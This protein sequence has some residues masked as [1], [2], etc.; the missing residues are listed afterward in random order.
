MPQ[1]APQRRRE[2][3]PTETTLEQKVS[4]KIYDLLREAHNSIKAIQHNF[5][6]SDWP[7]QENAVEAV[8]NVLYMAETI[9]I[10]KM[11]K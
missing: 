1:K 6:L 9:V 4:L 10:A 3:M 8:A 11:D 7:D 2:T 5:D